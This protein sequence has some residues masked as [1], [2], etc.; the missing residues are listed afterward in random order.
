MCRPVSAAGS[1]RR[2]G[3]RSRPGESCRSII[4]C[5]VSLRGPAAFALSPLDKSKGHASA[6]F[7]G[8]D[9]EFVAQAANAS[10]LKFIGLIKDLPVVDRQAASTDE[11]KFV[12][13]RL[14]LGHPGPRITKICSKN[15]CLNCLTRI[16]VENKKV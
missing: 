6:A 13:N 7:I 14:A 12:G 2:P 8:L 5:V 4:E 1:M 15:A 10:E 11:H 3:V 9:V 16:V